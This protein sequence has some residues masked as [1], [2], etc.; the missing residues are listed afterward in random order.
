MIKHIVQVTRAIITSLTDTHTH[1]PHLN[2]WIILYLFVSSLTYLFLPIFFF[3]SSFSYPSVPLFTLIS[4]T[5]NVHLFFSSLFFTDAFNKLKSPYLEVPG[6]GYHTKVYQKR[7][8]ITNSTQVILFK[9]LS[10]YISFNLSYWL[11]FLSF[12]LPFF[13]SVSPTLALHT[14]FF[15]LSCIPFLSS[16]SLM[17]PPLTTSIPSCYQL[18]HTQIQVKHAT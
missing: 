13:L 18:D 15:I 17:T 7:V 10:I 3:L 14:G 1:P 16:F 2:Y 8:I 6:I 11:Y 4:L 9:F 12:Y 5:Y